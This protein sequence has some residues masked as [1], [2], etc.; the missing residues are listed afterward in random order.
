MA[1]Y[2]FG[3]SVAAVAFL[4]AMIICVNVTPQSVPL[5][6]NLTITNETPA[7]VDPWCHQW[8]DPS[9][10]IVISCL[11]DSI[12]Y[13]NGSHDSKPIESIR[14]HRGNFPLTMREVIVA[15]LR[16]HAIDL[17]CP[18]VL[19]PTHIIVHNFGAPGATLTPS[20]KWYHEDEAYRKALTV[21]NASLAV[22]MLGTNDSKQWQNATYFIEHYRKL[23]SSLRRANKLLPVIILAPPPCFPDPN[24]FRKSGKC[25]VISGISC[26]SVSDSIRNASLTTSAVTDGVTYVDTF[27]GIMILYPQL[28]ALKE[29]LRI[30]C[31]QTARSNVSVNVATLPLMFSDG[32]HP[33]AKVTHD[34]GSIAATAVLKLLLVS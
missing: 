19:S 10:R 15:G 20:N 30:K 29:Q 21:V 25:T 14:R 4:V 34:I 7:G 12:T 17:R 31:N 24:V 23:I 33:T 16:S 13:G 18:F 5:F 27:H 2:R 3:L 6:S 8:S 28:A 9:I 26:E 22:V 32:V 1:S 11:G